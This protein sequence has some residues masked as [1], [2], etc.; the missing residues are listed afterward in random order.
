MILEAQR[1]RENMSQNQQRLPSPPPPSSSSLEQNKS[2]PPF[3]IP[4]LLYTLQTILSK[5]DHT[6]T[7]LRALT[8]TYT[9]FD[10]LVSDTERMDLLCNRILLATPIFERLFLHWSRNVRIF[11]L[12][13]L[14][15][16]LGRIWTKAHIQWSPMTRLLSSSTIMST[17]PSKSIDAGSTTT[18]AAIMDDTVSNT[19]ETLCNGNNCWKAL[20]QHHDVK[21]VNRLDNHRCSIQVHILLETMLNSFQRRYLEL[22]NQVTP[23]SPVVLSNSPSVI[24]S[25]HDLVHSN[26][27]PANSLTISHTVEKEEEKQ[28][29]HQ[30]KQKQPAMIKIRR[31]NSSFKKNHLFVR[32]ITA[33]NKEKW[34]KLFQFGSSASVFGNNT[35]NHSSGTRIIPHKSQKVDDKTKYGHGFFYTLPSKHNLLSLTNHTNNKVPTIAD[36]TM[37]GIKSISAIHSLVT[38]P[39]MEKGNV[40]CN[41]KDNGDS[42]DD[43]DDDDN[44]D[45]DN[46]DDEGTIDTSPPSSSFMPLSTTF[47]QTARTWKYMKTRQVY[48]DKTL[49][50]L[51]V[52]LHEY[53]LWLEKKTSI[54]GSVNK[55]DDHIIATTTF[56]VSSTDQQTRRMAIPGLILDW[57]R[58]WTISQM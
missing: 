1:T 30:Q 10:F 45:D 39:P 36:N 26:A 28:L 3:D 18:T 7:L 5:S 54:K 51:K 24:L 32:P 37:D 33:A 22:T 23:D 11:F 27:Y 35:I 34:K 6:I 2:L 52:V 55:D 20:Y 56:L 17:I 49:E 12:R 8:F 19:T 14:V 38:T 29:Q 47:I 43:N 48:A 41:E 15:W 21:D 9:H 57:P 25:D 58:N 16:R 40:E 4:F 31:R 13:C 50:E 53:S 46:D 44:D 42:D